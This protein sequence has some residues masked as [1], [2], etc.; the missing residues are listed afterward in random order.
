MI[1]AMKAR[2]FNP[3]DDNEADAVAILLWA[4]ETNGGMA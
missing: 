1:A 3:S 4:I 2:G